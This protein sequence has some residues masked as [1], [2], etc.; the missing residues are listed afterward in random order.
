MKNFILSFYIVSTL[1]QSCSLGFVDDLEKGDIRIRD[2]EKTWSVLD[3]WYPYFE[4]KK[5]DRDSIYKIYYPRITQSYSDEYLL[6]LHQMLLE[7]KDGHVALYLKNGK[8]LDYSTPRQLKD[9]K[10]YNFLVTKEYIISDINFEANNIF[11]YGFISDLGY[12]RVSSFSG[13]DGIKSID[14]VLHDLGNPKGLI[15]DVRH[16]GGGNANNA[17]NIVA[18]CIQEPL[19]TPGWIEKGEY[20]QGPIIQPDLK[21]NY[22]NQIV[23]LVNGKS[24]SSTEHFAMWMQQIEHVTI[25]GDT[26]GG[27]AGNPNLFYLPSGNK[28]RVS[29]RYFYKYDGE[30][31]EWN[32]IV[33]DILVEQKEADLLIGKDKQLEYAIE[34]L[35]KKTGH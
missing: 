30:P 23:V 1:L 7:L 27:G 16:N 13:F 24:F 14:V 20:Y 25:I 9:E 8:A 31:I 29:T 10:S 33:P 2:F 35:K 32:G 22:L 26:T 19:E 6:D 3:E 21:N 34:Y 5:I 28:I 15:I 17:L 12:L 18:K 4:F 11:L